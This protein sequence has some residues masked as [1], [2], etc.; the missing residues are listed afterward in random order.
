M[1][2]HAGNGSVPVAEVRLE[3]SATAAA[4]ERA[5][6]QL[7]AL[8][9]TAA[10][11]GSVLP[12]RL[13]AALREAMRAEAAP[14]AR[15]LAEVRGLSA[16]L[17]RRAE[18]TEIDLLAERRARADDLALLVELISEG[19]RSVDERLSRIERALALR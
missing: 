5:R 10:E 8:S 12:E 17:I 6:D 19:W 3:R 7:E 2:E 13:D 11:L 15:Q 18:R 14:V 16:Q 9:E 1:G 4:L